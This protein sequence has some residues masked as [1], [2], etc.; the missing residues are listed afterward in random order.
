M[1]KGGSLG[2]IPAGGSLKGF[3]RDLSIPGSTAST[4]SSALRALSSSPVRPNGFDRAQ[5]PPGATFD[6][7]PHNK[8]HSAATFAPQRTKSTPVCSHSKTVAASDNFY[9]CSQC[10]N[11]YERVEDLTYHVC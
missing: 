1:K 3:K 9:Y 10:T 11:F 8:A 4:S 6:R 2:K 7:R 5:P